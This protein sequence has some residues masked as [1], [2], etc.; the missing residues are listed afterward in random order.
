M[1]K[2]DYI[3]ALKKLQRA[4]QELVDQ[5][6]S[7]LDDHNGIFQRYQNPVLT[8]QHVPL[9]WRYELDEQRNPRLIERLRINSVFNTAAIQI[10]RTFCLVPRIEGADRKS[11]FAVAES[12][13][14]IDQFEFRDY[15]ILIPELDDSETNLYDMRLIQHQDG[16]IYGLFCVEY[17]DPKA[18][19]G[20]TSSAVAQAGIART[21]DLE[22]WHRLPNLKTPSPQQRNVVL[23]PEFIDG[24]YAFYTRPQDGFIEIGTGGGIGW[25]L[26]DDIQNAVISSEK[27]IDAKIYHTVKEAK[28][29]L[30][31]APLKTDKGWLQLAHGVRN[32]AAGLRYVLYMFMTDLKE[33]WKVTYSPAGYFMAP[34]GNERLGDVSNVLFS[35]GWILDEK[36]RV[37]IYYGSSDTRTHV[38]VAPLE[39]LVDYVID[40][41]PDAG[42]TYACVQQRIKMINSNLQWLKNENIER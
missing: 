28:N 2:N 38:A 18:P 6:N 36:G 22:L 5:K 7:P 41:P 9:T 31:P 40:T 3:E 19:P 12:S 21:K 11:F 13:T 4:R 29:G 15:P 23:H 8:D 26:A 17:K 27:I 14:G 37:Y 39:A 32:T 35:G 34:Q 30:G 42:R 24:K 33:P 1:N 16:W 20:D 25:G 10:G